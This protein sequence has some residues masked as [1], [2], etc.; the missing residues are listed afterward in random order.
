MLLPC[1]DTV[2]AFYPFGPIIRLATAQT[3]DGPSV[4]LVV[5]A[6]EETRI[7]LA[8]TLT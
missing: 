2:L 1:S 8:A 6:L 4:L 5:G 3:D 7:S